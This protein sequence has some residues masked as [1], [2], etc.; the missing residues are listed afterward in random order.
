[1]DFGTLRLR[2]LKQHPAFTMS[3]AS[4][5]CVWSRTEA[6]HKHIQRN[7]GPR[8]GLAQTKNAPNDAPALARQNPNSCAGSR[9]TLAAIHYY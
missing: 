8:H 9:A 1:M 7:K 5:G 6:G 4:H 3:L 2:P